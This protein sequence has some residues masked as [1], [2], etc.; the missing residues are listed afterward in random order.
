MPRVTP[1]R[2]VLLLLLCLCLCLLPRCL[3]RA[4]DDDT[5]ENHVV[6][7]QIKAE[8]ELLDQ[9]L[10]E[11]EQSVAV[12]RREKQLLA[13]RAQAEKEA[14]IRARFKKKKKKSQR[15]RK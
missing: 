13:Q 14:L 10:Q 3:L 5:K 4:A 7:E 15:T 6:H 2:S 11:T 1:S 12:E 9:K 8:K